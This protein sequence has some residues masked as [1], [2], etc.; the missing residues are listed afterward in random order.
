[1]YIALGDVSAVGSLFSEAHPVEQV[2]ARAERAVQDVERLGTELGLDRD[3]YEVF[4]GVDASGLDPM[5]RRLYDK[6]V[7]HFR[8]AGG[9][10]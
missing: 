9:D 6:T 7:V 8:R 3:L 4:T 10:R 1:M 2:R 5:A